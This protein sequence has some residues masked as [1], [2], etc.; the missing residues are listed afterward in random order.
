MIGFKRIDIEKLEKI[1]EM[2][3]RTTSKNGLEILSLKKLSECNVFRL[4]Y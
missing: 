2:K 1:I 4:L 3:Y